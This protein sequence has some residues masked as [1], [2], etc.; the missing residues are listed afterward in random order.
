MSL[1]ALL[2]LAFPFKQLSLNVSASRINRH[3][4]PAVCLVAF[5]AV[6]VHATNYTVKAG[7]G[8]NYTTIQSCSN[9]IVAG[10]TCTVY[11]GTY[12]EHPTISSGTA[13][14]YKTLTVN[15]GDMVYVQ[16][17]TVGSHVK[18]NGFQI[19]N[20]SSPTTS[21]ISVSSSSTDF[22]VTNNVMYACGG[23]NFAQSTPHISFGIFQGNTIS[24]PSSTSGS[25]NTGPAFTVHCDTCLFDSNDISHTSDGF[26]EIDGSNNV[27]R[28]NI[29]HDNLA[30]E[31]G[32]HSGNCH[33]DFVASEPNVPGGGYATAHN[34]IEGNEDYNCNS[35]A[36]CHMY[37]QQADACSG[38]CS[39]T[40]VRFNQGAHV[41]TA[42]LEND[43]S[44]VGMYNY[45]NT[46]VDVGTSLGGTGGGG[47]GDSCSNGATH[48]QYF[49]NL[50][51]Y[52]GTITSFNAIG[53]T[54]GT[55]AGAGSNLAWCTSG[56]SNCRLSG[57]NYG[58]GTWTGSGGIMSDPLLVAPSTSGME[59]GDNH[60]QSGSPALNAGTH[61]TTVAS[62][63]PGSGTS[64]VVNDAN[65]FQDGSA[66]QGVHPDCISVSATTSHVCISSV[67]YQTNTLTLT[68]SINRSPGNSVWLY[69]DSKGNQVLFGSAPN[70]GALNT[71]SGTAGGG[72]TPPP[73]VGLTSFAQ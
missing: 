69:S 29:F 4:V 11:A 24:Y 38:E 6:S 49:N 55:L 60:L 62:T 32:S 15:S 22:Y 51:F 70:I 19:Q 16:G 54:G 10:D 66:I 64:L 72:S 27:I 50:Y 41:A 28:N 30:S 57:Y 35:S 59:L 31:C 1:A 14:T 34:L 23:V 2:G 61:L 39:A 63:D 47:I 44:W 37:L 8:G 20:I 21:C 40:I 5:F 48:C 26:T 43:N 56:S 42:G 36:G 68:S 17:F 46:E 58:S 3:T 67:N 33:I 52:P 18:V 7:G 65:F 73:P 9:S 25:P 53:V 71:P 13:G 12:S 45:N